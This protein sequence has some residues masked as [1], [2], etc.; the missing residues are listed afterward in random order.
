MVAELA[1]GRF[2]SQVVPDDMA[3]Y[4]PGK[5]GII[6]AKLT[7]IMEELHSHMVV[8][9]MEVQVPSRFVDVVAKLAFML[10]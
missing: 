8:S 7:F 6:A 3:G 2:L 4:V 5:L 10:E 9:S 1:F